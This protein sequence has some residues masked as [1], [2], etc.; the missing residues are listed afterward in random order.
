MWVIQGLGVCVLGLATFFVWM[1]PY[2]RVSAMER[3]PQE[4]PV[5]D[6]QVLPPTVWDLL[7]DDLKNRNLARLFQLHAVHQNNEQQFL[8]PPNRTQ[9]LFRSGLAPLLRSESY[10]VGDAT[11]LVQTMRN[12]IRDLRIND[13]VGAAVEGLVPE[14]NRHRRCQTAETSAFVSDLQQ[15]IGIVQRHVLREPGPWRQGYVQPEYRRLLHP[16]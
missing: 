6:V 8:K 3:A 7:C 4:T 16:Q 11:V 9:Y 2:N 5:Q 1:V 12:W 15:I 13:V 10:G 14:E